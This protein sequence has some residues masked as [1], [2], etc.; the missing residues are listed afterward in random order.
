MI[1]TRKGRSQLLEELIAEGTLLACCPINITEE[2]AQVRR[3][4]LKLKRLQLA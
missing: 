3:Q 4:N 2:L 1:N